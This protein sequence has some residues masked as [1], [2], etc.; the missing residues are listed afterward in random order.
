[1]YS[2]QIKSLRLEKIMTNK[3]IC[4]WLSNLMIE[5]CQTE[6]KKKKKKKKKKNVSLSAVD[7]VDLKHP[8]VIYAYTRSVT[9]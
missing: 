1:M 6:K 3:G 4:E 2:Y 5:C 9:N 7:A 8:L